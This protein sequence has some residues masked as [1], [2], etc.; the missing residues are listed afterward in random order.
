MVMFLQQLH[1][2]SLDDARAMG[3]PESD[4]PFCRTEEGITKGSAAEIY[5]RELALVTN[6]PRLSTYLDDNTRQ[7]VVK[8][9]SRLVDALLKSP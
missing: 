5:K 6:H 1:S 7:Q 4:Y 8:S 2:F 9:C 3:V